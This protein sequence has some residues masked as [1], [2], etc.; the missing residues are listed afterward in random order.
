MAQTDTRSYT[1]QGKVLD[2]ETK[3]PIP[4][5]S[6]KVRGTEK[7]TITN[8]EGD[9]LIEGLSTEKNTLIISCYGYCDTVCENY[10][11]HGKTPHIYLTQEVLKLGTVTIQAQKEK[12]EGTKA[13]SQVTLQKS[14]IRSNPTQSLA[15][16]IA[17]EQG[18]TLT[19]TGTN[20]QLPVIHGL[21]GNRILI[22]NNGLKHGFQNWGTEHAPEIDI[23]SANNIT[24]VKGAAGVRFGPEALGGAII[25]EPNPLHLSEPFFTEIG[26]GFQ[27][28][29]RGINTSF[30]TG[31]GT[32]KWSYFLN[33]N[34]TKIGDRHTPDYNLTNSG[35]EEK[36]IGLGTRY[37]LKN[38]D[39]KVY[40][41]YVN[42]NLALLRSSVAESLNTLVRAIN[43]D[44]PTFLRPF[45]YTINEPNQVTEHHLGKAEINWLYSDDGKL[46]FRAGKQLNKRKEFDVRRNADRPII[47]LDLI[48][49][50]YQL[51]WKH[52]D[53]FKLDG[54]LGVQYFTQDNDNNPGTGTTAFIPN[55]NTYRTSAFLIESLRFGSNILEAG[56]RVD[57]E[58]N[59]VRGRDTGQ[60]IFRDE[61]SFANLTSSLGYVKEISENSTFRTNFGT[62]WRTPNMAEL[63]SFGQH[64]SRTS[65]GLLRY[66]VNDEG[67]FRT[68]KVLKMQ[69]ST[70]EAERGY[71]FINEFETHQKKNTYTLT[72][73][74]HYIENYIFDRPM[75]VIGTIR[76]PMPAF[77][78]DQADAVFVG[79]D[80]SW[81]RDW[82]NQLSGT[83]GFSYLWSK[84]IED[85]EPLINQPPITLNYSLNWNQPKLWKFEASK[86]TIKPSYSVR[87][88]LA[89]RTVSPED[90]AD[91]SVDIG[92]G[93]EIFDF[94]SAPKGYF[95]L[96]VGW[97]FK[98][99]TLSASITV[100][101]VLNM[102]Y[103]DYLNEM[104]YFA[105]EPG[106]NMLFTL[107]YLFTAKN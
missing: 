83:F 80:F 5:A 87:Q 6:I 81:K 31:K 35:K 84:N 76:G 70:V 66:Y 54:L 9:F 41:S 30:E 79:S 10:H 65:Y 85:N 106:R 68:N 103:R 90:S 61:Y 34:Y 11:Q 107:N 45:S 17:Q 52:P 93:S 63:F 2:V 8:L 73:Y 49:S 74:S 59:N 43:S 47:D 38:W 102:R 16:S 7:F 55:Y 40:Y 58:R 18:V 51:E 75:G 15:A 21:Y 32:K 20:V 4:Y 27:T 37:A 22:L 86:L 24:I 14:E 46:T 72:V 104:R 19:S 100:K 71:K 97:S 91:E 96:D 94:M 12:E 33:G 95:L 1:I 99:K 78:F 101:N 60:N 28:N 92:P 88:F 42:Q 44:E 3:E 48:T 53:W 77:V 56:V 98:Y 13:I 26:T 89:P 57:Y 64:G 36:A 69:E 105:D 67:E 50:D 29:G 25:V 82:S 23:S 39:F 62:A